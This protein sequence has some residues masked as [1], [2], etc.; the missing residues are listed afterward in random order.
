MLCAHGKPDVTCKG[1][2]RPD[3]QTGKTI[4]FCQR[5][6]LLGPRSERVYMICSG[7]AVPKELEATIPSPAPRRYFSI[8][9][10][11]FLLCPL[12]LCFHFSLLVN[13]CGCSR[14]RSSA[15]PS[16]WLFVRLW[17]MCLLVGLFFLRSICLSPFLSVSI[18]LSL[19]SGCY[20]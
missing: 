7:S 16:L 4:D 18:S 2:W 12:I 11:F 13:V 15:P 3:T 1:K 5:M 6:G 8:S 9:I 17:N 10:V 20:L 14:Y 19:F